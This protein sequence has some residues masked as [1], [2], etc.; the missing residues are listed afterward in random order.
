M[1]TQDYSFSKFSQ[2]SFYEGLNAHL[3]DMADLSRDKRIVD[4]A[5]GTGGVTSLIVGRLN[6]ARDSVVIA[7]DH[8]A[9]ALKQAMENLR[10]RG[11]SVIQF[12]HSQVEGLS[13]SLNRESV[14]T[15]VFCNAIHYI[16]DKD[17]LLEDIT[18]SLNPGGKFAFNTSFYE[19]S[20][21]PESLEYYRKWMFKS[22][23]TLRRE[24]G[25]KPTRAEKVES[26]KQL[27]VDQYRELL[28]KH[29]M[30][31]VKQD[32]ETVQVP[33]EGWLD[34][35]G[36][37]DFI[38]GTLPGVPLKEASAA[39]QSGVRQTFEE[40]NITHVPR[41]WLGIIAVRS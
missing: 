23:R 20:H 22:I 38:E 31:I 21:P 33:I 3:V 30:T 41:S 6:N 28:E 34:I 7:V 26:R 19:G 11:D 24:Y 13:E 10:G 5:C 32:I 2:N 9:G 29:G 18:R 25:L 14:D 37:Q 40:M 1:T 12:V 27:T 17:A 36:F 8:S 4:L 15:V 16:P 39:L 35:S